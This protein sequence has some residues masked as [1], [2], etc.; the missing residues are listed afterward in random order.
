MTGRTLAACTLFGTIIL[1]AWQTLSNA[2]LPWHQQTMHPFT[3][4]TAAAVRSLRGQAPTNGMYVNSH[5]AVV[6][7][8]ATAD[9]VDQTTLLPKMMGRQA[10]IDLFVAAMLCIVAARARDPSPTAFAAV[11]GFGALA[12]AAVLELS[13]WNWYGF[14]IGWSLVN[15]IDTAI[16]FFVSGFAIAWLAGKM[17]GRGV[18]VPAGAGYTAPAAG[19]MQP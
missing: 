2:A 8:S 3:D 14:G 17:S 1:F 12:V 4:T 16:S 13:N 11:A 18:N 9:Y 7:M 5:G 19:V 10:A 6:M 15:V